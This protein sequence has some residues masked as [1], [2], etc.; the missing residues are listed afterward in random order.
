MTI[1]SLA[2]RKYAWCSESF[3]CL[4]AMSSHVRADESNGILGVLHQLAY[5][6]E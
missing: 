3:E 1:S 5:M 6:L 2:I 4:F